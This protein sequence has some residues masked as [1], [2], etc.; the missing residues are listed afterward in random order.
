MYFCKSQIE[1]QDHETYNRQILM[2]MDNDSKK[3]EEMEFEDTNF[4][5]ECLESFD[6]AV[7][8]IEAEYESTSKSA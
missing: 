6:E 5:N 2:A 1:Y 4:V 3:Y 7:S 8:K